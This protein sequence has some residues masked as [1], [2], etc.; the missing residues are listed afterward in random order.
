MIQR[1]Y[2]DK[3]QRQDLNPQNLRLESS[4]LTAML[5]TACHSNN[6]QE[7][8]MNTAHTP[9]GQECV[10]TH[11]IWIAKEW[12]DRHPHSHSGIPQWHN[13]QRFKFSLYY[14][15][16]FNA[17]CMYYKLMQCVCINLTSRQNVI[18]R[19]ISLKSHVLIMVSFIINI[20]KTSK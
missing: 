2:L 13:Y 1:A 10:H 4:L 7:I 14:S 11:S 5:L 8:S 12:K 17:V 16:C 19:L 3:W 15:K 6:W 9:S 20:M 18:C